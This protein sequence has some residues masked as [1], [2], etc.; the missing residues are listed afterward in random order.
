M[1]SSS[2]TTTTFKTTTGST[3]SVRKVQITKTIQKTLPDVTRS[4]L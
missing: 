2:H 3:K 4:S 1:S